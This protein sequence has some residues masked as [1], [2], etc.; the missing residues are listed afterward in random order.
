[1]SRATQRIMQVA[2]K[3][4]KAQKDTHLSVDHLFAALFEDSNVASAFERAALRKDAALDA[5][6]SLRGSQR[7]TSASAEAQFDALEVRIKST[8]L[9]LYNISSQLFM[10]IPEIRHQHRGSG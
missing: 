4:Q 6:S 7:V 9:E 1:M 10:L 2:Q 3:K 5:L 8:D